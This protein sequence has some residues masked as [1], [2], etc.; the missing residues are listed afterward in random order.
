MTK[1]KTLQTVYTSKFIKNEKANKAFL[2]N[3]KKTDYA[4]LVLGKNIASL[5]LV[6]KVAC[7]F[8]C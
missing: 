1:A 2:K 4:Q 7:L 6:G 8:M 3:R 5:N